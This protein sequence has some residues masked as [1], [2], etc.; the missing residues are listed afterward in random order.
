MIVKMRGK[1]DKL[2][3]TVRDTQKPYVRFSALLKCSKVIVMSALSAIETAAN[4]LLTVH[5]TILT[6]IARICIDYISP[7][8]NIDRDRS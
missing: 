6:V 3:L 4:S 8:P 2:N 5:T 1:C 7:H